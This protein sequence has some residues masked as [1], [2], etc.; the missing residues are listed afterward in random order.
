MA[1]TMTQK[2]KEP[3]KRKLMDEEDC[4]M[5]SGQTATFFCQGK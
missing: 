5:K 2:K 4:P 1:S 3:H